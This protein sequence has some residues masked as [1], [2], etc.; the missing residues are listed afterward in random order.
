M[1][2]RGLRLLA[3]G[4]IWSAAPVR[5]E[6]ARDLA[7]FGFAELHTLSRET[8]ARLRD[9]LQSVGALLLADVPGFGAVAEQA[10]SDLGSCLQHGAPGA[11]R[12]SLAGGVDRLTVATTTVAGHAQPLPQEALA[13][14]P[15][16]ARSAPALRG[17]TAYL[18]QLF[19]RGVDA[20]AAVEEYHDG[21]GVPEP[22]TSRDAGQPAASL[23]ALVRSGTYLEHFHRYARRQPLGSDGLALEA[24]TDAGLFLAVAVRWRLAGGSSQKGD[25]GLQVELPD[26]CK[27][28]AEGDVASVQGSGVLVLIGQGAHEWLPH[29]D[30]RPAPHSLVLGGSLAE[31]LA[32]AVMV[33]PADDWILPRS[34]LAATSSHPVLFG[35]WRHRA[36]HAMA[37]SDCSGHGSR[38]LG[39]LIHGTD[40][41]LSTTALSRRL[42]DQALLCSGGDLWCWLQC[43]PV[44]HLLCE[45]SEAICWSERLKQPC[46]EGG[47]Q[48]HYASC[49][50]TCPASPEQVS[51]AGSR[52]LGQGFCNGHLTAMHVTGFVWGAEEVPCLVYLSPGMEL[53]TALKFWPAVVAS[54]II[55]VLFEF[56]VMRRRQLVSRP[57]STQ[58]L[59]TYRVLAYASTTTL[60]YLMMLVAMTYSYEL[61]LA[62]IGGCTLGHA[63]FNMSSRVATE[64]KQK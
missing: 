31:R 25:W 20:A 50:P 45:S 9:A 33:L 22:G 43:M 17:L 52:A 40:G 38:C 23:E 11:A 26:G 3:L 5:A 34:D 64:A 7:R 60:G 56:A 2:T 10:L 15:G 41:C 54:A 4:A 55:G 14:C 47:K 49:K 32:Y 21:A 1:R 24:H 8:R 6:V 36:Q 27:V 61:F 58:F 16:L 59:C 57:P 18:L 29:L 19:A 35:E 30:L 53:T 51:D 28:A 62:A 37:D 48:A 12:S 63:L 13:A 42:S 46:S 39:A 44:G